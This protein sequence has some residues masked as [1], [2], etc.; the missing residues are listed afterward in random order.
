MTQL[1]NGNNTTFIS[2]GPN[3]AG[4]TFTIFG[5]DESFT[6]GDFIEDEKHNR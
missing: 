4:K 3:E 5:E 2:Y 1:L 6:P